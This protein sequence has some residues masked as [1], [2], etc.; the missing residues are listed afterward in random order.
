MGLYKHCTG[1]SESKIKELLLPAQ[2]VW[3]SAEEAVE[4]GLADSIKRTF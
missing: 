2:D 3:L 4:H 1:L